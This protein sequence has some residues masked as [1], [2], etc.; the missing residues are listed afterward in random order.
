MCLVKL[1][2]PSAAGPFGGVFAI[3][4]AGTG[5]A[6][7]APAASSAAPAKAAKPVGAK[8]RA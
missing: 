3:Q 1:V 8:F 7:V 5:T 6:A 2:N 4:M